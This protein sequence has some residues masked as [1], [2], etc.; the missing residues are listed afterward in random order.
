M[1]VIF[2]ISLRIIH[3]LKIQVK[4]FTKIRDNDTQFKVPL[5]RSSYN[6]IG[7]S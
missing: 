7:T 3:I 4:I 5:S 2:F 6:Q 1:I